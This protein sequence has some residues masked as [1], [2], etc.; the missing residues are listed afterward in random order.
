MTANHPS[1]PIVGGAIARLQTS[2]A[3]LSRVERVAADFVLAQPHIVATKAI[4]EVAASANV[5]DATYMRLA[6][7][8]G[9]EGFAAFKRALVADLSAHSDAIYDGVEPSDAPAAIA[10]K[11]IRADARHLMD[12]AEVLDYD[13]FASVVTLMDEAPRV[14]VWALGASSPFGL[15][16]HQRLMRL[17]LTS[18]FEI[19]AYEQSVQAQLLPKSTLVMVVSRTGWPPLLE[20]SCV[21]ARSRGAR[22]VAITGQR[23]TNLAEQAEHVLH[24]SV[25]SIRPDVL[26]SGVPYI[27]LLDALYIALSVK[28][29]GKEL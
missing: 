9:Y 8:I 12:T 20:Q 22:I 3:S 27:A 11:V 26:T 28:R 25:R 10:S 13:A 24:A 14:V 18:A 5:A 16:L 15:Y 21:T 4:Q 29:E 19:D 1:G 17:G 6:R 23:D 7:R 2:L